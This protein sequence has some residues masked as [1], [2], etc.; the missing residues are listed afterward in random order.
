MADRN[1]GEI[2]ARSLRVNIV[3]LV[4]GYRPSSKRW[5]GSSCVGMRMIGRLQNPRTDRTCYSRCLLDSEFDTM[6]TQFL[7]ALEYLF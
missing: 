4:A 1:L 2:L 5:H 3:K 6:G 7:A